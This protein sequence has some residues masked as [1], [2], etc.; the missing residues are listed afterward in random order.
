MGLLLL[1]GAEV[2]SRYFLLP[3]TD[4]Q[5][6]DGVAISYFF[7]HN[8]LWLRILALLLL[9]YPVYSIIKEKKRAQMPWLVA[10]VVG[11]AIVFYYFN[12]YMAVVKIYQPVQVKTFA[13]KTQNRI[14]NDKLVIGVEI[15]GVAK[16]YPLQ[17]LG[18]HHQVA[19]SI[20][21]TP[22][23][24]TYCTLCRS[25]RVF[26]SE[27]EGKPA[28][29]VLL[30]LNKF[31][32]VFED[33]A[34]KSWWQQETGDAI[35]GRMKGKALKE[36]PS[37]QV[38]LSTWFKEHPGALVMQPDSN[39]TAAYALA[40]DDKAFFRLKYMQVNEAGYKAKS[41]VVGILCNGQAK[42]YDLDALSYAKYIED[43][44]SGVPVL[45]TLETDNASFHAWNRTV[46]GQ[47]LHFE[48]NAATNEIK[49]VNT[50]ST[51][52]MQGTCTKGSSQ[53]TQLQELQAYLETWKSWSSFH[54]ESKLYSLK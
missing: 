2:L 12:F 14:G 9:A 4:I 54:P 52:N 32:S 46:K 11:Y 29:F 45:L 10:I 42:A 53:G 30:G 19:D 5:E 41:L 6:K 20:G 35:A 21:G 8:I 17:I 26:S 13:P 24:V 38:T 34:T 28:G 31:N 3:F 33:E 15:N 1:F 39:Y 40:S 44:L 48:K 37:H 27:I 36:I 51:W 50:Q 18:Y 23:V 25:A 47:R 43:S 16:A 22:V 49:D 7:Y